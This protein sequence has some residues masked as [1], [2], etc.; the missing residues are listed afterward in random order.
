L[1]GADE[2]VRGKAQ[3]GVAAGGVLD[4]RQLDRELGGIEPSEA[5][6]SGGLPVASWRAPTCARSTIGATWT[7]PS[8]RSTRHSQLAISMSLVKA[9]TTPA[10]LM[11]RVSPL[12]AS[13]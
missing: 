7:I 8:A 13:R 5:V 11:A 4:R 3:A 9:G 6:V 2:R 1:A 10:F 12:A